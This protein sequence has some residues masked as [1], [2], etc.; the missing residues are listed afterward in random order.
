MRKFEYDIERFALVEK[1]SPKKQA[2]QLAVLVAE[3][4]RKGAEGWELLGL[5]SFDLVGGVLGGDKGA[6]TLTLWKR[7]IGQDA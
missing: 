3:L 5:H 6:V 1:W 2:E 7:E 4:D